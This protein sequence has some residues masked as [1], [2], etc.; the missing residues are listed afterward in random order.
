M[1]RR[2][3][4]SVLV[5]CLGAL[6]CA[7]TTAIAETLTAQGLAPVRLGMTIAAAER[8]L[9]A[10]LGRL[11]RSSHGFSTEPQSVE[12]CWFWQRRDGQRPDIAYMAERGRI[13][14][15]DIVAADG[16]KPPGHHRAR[17][18]RRQSARRR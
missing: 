8:A 4:F 16:T 12:I 11:S 7:P 6:Y 14:R 5:A 9:H 10:K 2:M 17:H 1:T 3:L 13:V 15:I 18:R